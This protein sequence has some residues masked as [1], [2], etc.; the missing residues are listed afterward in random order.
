[1][2][3]VNMNM[4]YNEMKLIRKKVEQIEEILIPEEEFSNKELEEM[5]KLRADALSE[6]KKKQTIRVEDL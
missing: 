4:L 6:H 2:E 3:N 5:D 1:M